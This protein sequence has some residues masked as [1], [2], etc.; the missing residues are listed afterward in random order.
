MTMMMVMMMTDDYGEDYD[1]H[2]DGDDIDYG[3]DDP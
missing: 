1:D 2:N 3:D